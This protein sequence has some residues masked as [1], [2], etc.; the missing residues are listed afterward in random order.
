[1]NKKVINTILRILNIFFLIIF[2]I[3]FA[4][5]A[6]LAFYII[7]N[8]ISE[9]A[10]YKAPIRFYTIVSPSMEPEIKVYDII[11]SKKVKNEDDLDIGD[12][13]TF[14][15]KAINTG[16][17][18]VTHRIHNIEIENG[19]KYYITKGDNN[20]NEDDGRITFENIQG[21]VIY[22][23]PSMGKIQKFI[24]SKIGWILI[25][26]LPAVLIIL[27]DLIKLTKVFR[28]KKQIDE[29]EPVKEVDRYKETEENK[30][31][32]ALVEKA[33]KINKKK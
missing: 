6:F 10:N 25:V 1:M 11:I 2:V 20:H 26:L 17:Y 18:T 7:T 15:S 5:A 29:I 16:R 24:S 23:I 22:V 30:R 33:D 27:F 3:L 14:Y 9:S 31:I 13:I 4:I 12:V 21:K 32:R 28:I 8:K 19:K